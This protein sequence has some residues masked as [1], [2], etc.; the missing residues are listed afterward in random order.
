[1]SQ[2]RQGEK[3]PRLTRPQEGDTKRC[4]VEMYLSDLGADELGVTT[5]S[6]II[7]VFAEQGIAVTE[8]WACR[9]LE[10]WR[11][12]HSVPAPGVRWR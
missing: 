12:D 3:S 10:E 6:S 5:G 9:I 1:V 8:R 2:R 11:F 4:R 7:A